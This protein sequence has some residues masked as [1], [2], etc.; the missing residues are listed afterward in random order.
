[1]HG[2]PKEY[3]LVNGLTIAAISE[4]QMLAEG[5]LTPVGGPTKNEMR[6]GEGTK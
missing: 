4:L 3:V 6:W 1:M 2:D 5:P